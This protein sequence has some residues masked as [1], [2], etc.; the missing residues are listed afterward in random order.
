[1]ESEVALILRGCP[2][3]APAY[4]ALVQ[5]ADGEPGAAAVLAEFAAYVA[6]VAGV[7]ER[8]LPLLE[9]CLVGVEEVARRSEDAEELVVWSFF[10]ALSA[11]DVR[12]LEP[13]LGSHTRTLLDDADRGDIFR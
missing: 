4:L 6:T 1:M 13:W 9:R 12:R 2:E 3:F 5:E 11:D 7:V 10:D 8:S